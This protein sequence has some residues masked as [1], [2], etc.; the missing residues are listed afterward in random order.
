MKVFQVD[1][2]IPLFKERAGLLAD[3]HD[4]LFI[5]LVHLLLCKGQD[6]VVVSAA[7]PLVCRQHHISGRALLGMFKVRML[8]S[9]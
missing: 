4:I 3:G 6:I 8:Q 7:Q 9:A 5:G 2:D 1:R